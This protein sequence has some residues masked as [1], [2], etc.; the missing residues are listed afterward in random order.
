M[1]PRTRM[2]L[3][4]A[5]L[6]AGTLFAWSIVTTDLYRFSLTGGDLTQFHGTAL[7]NPLLTACFYGALVFTIALRWAVRLRQGGSDARGEMHLAWLALAGVLWTAGNLG[8]ECYLFYTPLEAGARSVCSSS[9]IV[10]PFRTPCFVAF[11]IFL[12]A[13]L[14]TVAV[15]RSL[16]RRALTTTTRPRQLGAHDRIA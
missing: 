11:L 10:S 12:A 3:Q 5:V 13:F 14:I 7:P 4:I 16:R 1:Q 2:D 6:A 9:E 15:G 8:Y